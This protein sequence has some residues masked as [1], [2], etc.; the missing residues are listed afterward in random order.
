LPSLQRL[1]LEEETDTMDGREFDAMTRILARVM[2]RRGAFRTLTS[3][4]LASATARYGLN[5]AEANTG[6]C[7]SEPGEPCSPGQCCYNH[8]LVC[9]STN[10]RTCGACIQGGFFSFCFDNEDCCSHK[11]KGF[12]FPTCKGEKD[13]GKCDKQNRGVTVEG[14]KKCKKKGGG[15]GH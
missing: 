12:L 6:G 10:P 13:K 11:C 2:P 4:A 14:K 1:G 15:H 5:A 3:F 8:G 7:I 9:R